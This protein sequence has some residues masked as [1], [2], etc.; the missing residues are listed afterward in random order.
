MKPVAAE[1]Y[2]VVEEEDAG[3]SHLSLT[4]RLMSWLRGDPPML[5]LLH[6]AIV[7]GLLVLFV[8]A[9]LTAGGPGLN[10][11]IRFSDVKLL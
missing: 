6:I 2:E 8:L 7:L 9:V 11:A 3:V 4:S 5:R 10:V 1:A